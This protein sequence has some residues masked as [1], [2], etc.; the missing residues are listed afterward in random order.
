MLERGRRIYIPNSAD[1]QSRRVGQILKARGVEVTS[2]TGSVNSAPNGEDGENERFDA[3]VDSDAMLQRMRRA[4]LVMASPAGIDDD[5]EIETARREGIDVVDRTTVMEALFDQHWVIGVTGTHGRGTVTSM[6]AWILE[7]DG[8]E[9]G[10]LLSARSLDFDASTRDSSGRWFIVELDERIDS[11]RSLACDFVICNFLELADADELK[12]TVAS[13]ARF[14]ES[15]RRLKESFVNLDCMGNRKL[16][17][18]LAMRPTGYAVEHRTEFRADDISDGEPCRAFQALHRDRPI[19]E[20]T[21]QIAGHYNVVNALGAIACAHR[22]GVGTDIIADAL[23]TYRGLENRY[24]VARGGGVTLVKDRGRRP[25]QMES[26]VDTTRRDADGRVLVV[27]QPPDAGWI[28]AQ[29]RQGAEAVGK[30]DYIAV[31]D[32]ADEVSEPGPTERTTALMD[33]LCQPPENAHYVADPTRLVSH[34]TERVEP[35]DAL[36]FFGNDSFLRRADHVQ[37]ELAARAAKTE[38]E[39]EQPPLDGPLVEGDDEND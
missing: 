39:K 24:T 12:Q 32:A 28:D 35:G 38:P 25:A 19:G 17:R 27:F 18:R 5:V 36:V 34:L 6:L 16:V 2:A 37:A 30:A 14:F 4:D 13:M 9:P 31:L 1:A 33:A 29:A 15:N 11:R 23:Q 21:L 20:F 3:A 7:C 22:I 26:V 8:R 10:F